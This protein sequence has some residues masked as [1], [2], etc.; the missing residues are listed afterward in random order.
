MKKF[1]LLVLT[2]II[3][4]AALFSWKR[5]YEEN[6][7]ADEKYL[8]DY[9]FHFLAIY[10]KNDRYFHQ[11]IQSMLNQNYENYE[12]T[13]FID[14]DYT[15]EADKVRLNAKK[16]CKGHLVN[17]VEMD[18]D[19]PITL[20]VKDAT[21]GL[22]QDTVLVLLGNNCMF[23]ESSTLKELNSIYKKHPSVQLT[24][25]NF[26]NFPTFLI[27]KMPL[28]YRKSS[29][30]TILARLFKNGTLDKHSSANLDQ[31]FASFDEVALE[32]A[33]YINHPF[34]LKVR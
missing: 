18:Q 12:I 6:F 26:M 11:K 7:A 4:T 1:Y 17:F 19:A 15:A 25:S 10:E 29:F 32:K 2:A 27:N 30:K 31:A 21:A 34:Y 22:K 13:I 8:T 28:D 23:T 16:V 14:K 5:P 20:I 33:L 3:A 24:Y 9:D